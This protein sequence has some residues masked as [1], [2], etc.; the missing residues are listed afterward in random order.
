LEANWPSYQQNRRLR[1]QLQ[2]ISAEQLVWRIRKRAKTIT[3]RLSESLM[4]AALEE[5]ALSSPHAGDLSS[6][7]LTN[8][9]A[10][11]ECYGDSTTLAKLIEH[12]HAIDAQ[13]GN[14]NFRLIQ[15]APFNLGGIEQM[16]LAVTAADMAESLEARV[17]SAGLNKLKELL[18]SQR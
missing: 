3:L 11:I 15:N 14:I 9:P 18:N 1:A 5:V 7:D 13:P 17:K 6:F 4:P 12:H 2:T 10:I 8:A 16:P